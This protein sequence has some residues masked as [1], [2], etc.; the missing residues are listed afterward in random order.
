MKKIYYTILG[1][2]RG[3]MYLI[4]QHSSDALASF[5]STLNS[6][7]EVETRINAAAAKKK[8]K[9]DKLAQQVASL[10]ATKEA[11]ARIASKIAS[12]LND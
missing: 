12:F 3:E 6:L 8:A 7:N 10:A 4:G 1:W 2:I 9:A 5:Q 11:N